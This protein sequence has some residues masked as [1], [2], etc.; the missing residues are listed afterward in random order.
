MFE[1]DPGLEQLPVLSTRALLVHCTVSALYHP[2]RFAKA[3]LVAV[4][5][6]SYKRKGLMVGLEFRH[7]INSILY[8][9]SLKSQDG[10]IESSLSLKSAIYMWSHTLAAA[11]RWDQPSRGDVGRLTEQVDDPHV[12]EESV[13]RKTT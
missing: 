5:T 2:R 9:A 7:P 4:R 13:P 11:A 8:L 3:W 12:P 6:D 10:V 1:V